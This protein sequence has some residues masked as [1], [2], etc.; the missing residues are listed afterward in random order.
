MAKSKEKK[1]K[2]ESDKAIKRIRNYLIFAFIFIAILG[3]T[4]GIL[5]YYEIIGG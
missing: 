3:V 4:L 2:K 1:F 5:N